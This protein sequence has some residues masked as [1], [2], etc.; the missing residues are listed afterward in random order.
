ME[1]KQ[2]RVVFETDDPRRVLRFINLMRRAAKYSTEMEER[3]FWRGLA[4]EMVNQSIG[5]VLGRRN[6]VLRPLDDDE[7]ALRRVI[8]G[9]QPYP[10]LSLMDA[11]RV[12]VHF[13][14][15]LSARQLGERLYVDHRT[16]DRW[17]SEY[18]K[19]M[20]KKYDL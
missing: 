14:L 13:G 9:D 15:S 7:V 18:K 11:R 12:I 10:V 2:F 6:G 8:K 4:S 3:A 19:G 16:I 17:R 20:W 1:G 5:M